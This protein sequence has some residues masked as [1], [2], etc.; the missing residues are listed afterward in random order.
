MLTTE[1]LPGAAR[2]LRSSLCPRRCVPRR[3][4]QRCLDSE[5][6]AWKYGQIA[7]SLIYLLLTGTMREL[8]FSVLRGGTVLEG[9]ELEVRNL[10]V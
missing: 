3:P 5:S 1:A 6:T 9:A 2:L 4:G 7:A 8:F 10:E